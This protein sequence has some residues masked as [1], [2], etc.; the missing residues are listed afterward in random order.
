VLSTASLRTTKSSQSQASTCLAA[1][2]GRISVRSRRWTEKNVTQAL[3]P[4]DDKVV[5][6]VL[7]LFLSAA[8]LLISYARNR[9]DSYGGPIVFS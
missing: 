1:M 5:N 2:S 8:E 6:A 9:K 4:L 7:M 3:C